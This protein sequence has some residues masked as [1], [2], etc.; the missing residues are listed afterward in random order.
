MS[1]ITELLN[2]DAWVQVNKS[3]M[4]SMGVAE[5][6]IYSELVARSKYFEVRGKLTD[7][8]FFY[9]TVTDLQG[10]TSYGDKGQRAAIKKLISLGLVEMKLKGTPAV[11][12][13]K[14]LDNDEILIKLIFA[15][16]GMIEALEPRSRRINENDQ[17]KTETCM[18]SQLRPMDGTSSAK[19][20]VSEARMES[21]NLPMDVTETFQWT[22]L[23]PSN[24]R[25]NNTNL[26]NTN[27]NKNKAIATATANVKIE[28]GKPEND[29]ARDEIIKGKTET[30][31][32]ADPKT[33][34][35]QAIEMWEGEWKVRGKL[36]MSDSSKVKSEVK[37]HGL[38]LFKAALEK[39]SS[40]G[41]EVQ[42]PMNY[43]SDILK[44]W[45]KKGIN[46]I[47]GV[48]AER[49]QFEKEKEELRVLQGQF[50]KRSGSRDKE[51]PKVSNSKYDQFYR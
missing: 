50:A 3:L 49:D 42:F 4:F 27:L 40:G 47:E 51:P 15:G 21:K 31:A 46:T 44:A 9:N 36:R 32:A 6:I 48:E 5:T 22:E 7:D 12:H 23:V 41:D 38:P 30:C 18:D 19:L 10:G 8:G 43:V 16:N 13:F 20:E 25:T 14:I 39:A 33:D 24:G 37:K 35:D 45:A 1:A 29:E 28:E 2:K 17:K 26:N 34:F 11:R